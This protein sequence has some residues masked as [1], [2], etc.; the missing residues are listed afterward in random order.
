[1]KN[2]KIVNN[3]SK[4]ELALIRKNKILRQQLAYKSHMWFFL[5][6]MSNYIKYDFAPFHYEMFGLTEDESITFIDIT[7]FRGSAKSTIMTLSFP[8]WAVIGNL[9]NK[10]ILIVSQTQTQARLHL[11][12]L[13]RELE[14]NMQLK[15]DIGPFQELND[16]WSSASIVI[17]KYG[18]R[19]SAVSTDQSIRGVRHY[20]HRPDL[21]IFD[22]IEDLASV[23]TKEQ[24]DKTYDWV[25]GDA[26]PAGDEKTKIVIIG[27]LLHE[28]S[29]QMR[30]AEHINNNEI[31]GVFRKYPLLDENRIPTW[32]SRFP[33]KDAIDN[34]RRRTVSEVAW[35]REYMLNL[36]AETEQVI[37]KDWIKYYKYESMPSFKDDSFEFAACGVD[38]AISQ[39]TA[40]DKTAM[41]S[42]Y[43]FRV[44]GEYKI[45]IQPNPINKQL[46]F[47]Q[48]ID[49]IKQIYTM[50]VP[51]GESNIYI[52]QVA[53]QEAAV[54]QLKHEE[55]EVEGVKV[56]GDKRARLALTSSFIKSGI[57]VFPE[58]GCEELIEQLVGFGKEKHDDL[59]DAF[60]LLVLKISELIDKVDFDFVIIG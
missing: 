6:Y 32:E 21:I 10:F 50:L 15:A 23:K 57:V 36:I 41:V 20:Q 52:E 25:M 24:R 48:T 17:P 12:N 1:M 2:N 22:D 44:N 38:L 55:I 53:Y 54:Q 34:L 30:L 3:L 16:E 5:L 40:S 56:S 45:Y 19:I 14:N 13:K 39:N 49:S 8:I 47:P 35:Q 58:K 42:A 9:Q 46:N 28:D 60:S 26:I 11:S 4:D 29:T 51:G 7:A 33:N 43:V 18:A 27:N 59:A 31:D 37:H